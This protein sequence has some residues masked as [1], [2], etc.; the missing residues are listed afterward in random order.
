[1]PTSFAESWTALTSDFERMDDRERILEFL[2]KTPGVVGDIAGGI[3]LRQE[4]LVALLMTLE[5]E[6]LI[7]W[8]RDAWRLPES[9][10]V[11]GQGDHP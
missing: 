10:K 3:G 6:S 1:M 4:Q 8:D 11:E 2:A 9:P 7:V 5:K